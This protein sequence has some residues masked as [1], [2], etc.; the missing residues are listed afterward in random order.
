MA[1]VVVVVE[2]FLA[3]LA[4]HLEVGITE[5]VELDS[6]DQEPTTG[7]I[8]RR[9]Y[10]RDTEVEERLPGSQGSAFMGRTVLRHQLHTKEAKSRM[11][12]CIRLLGPVAAAE[13]R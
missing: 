3:A 13:L 2:K 4:R 1:E 6:P 12:S 7:F 8:V 5:Q 11:V 10:A 9:S